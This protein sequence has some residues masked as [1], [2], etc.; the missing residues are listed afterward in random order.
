MAGRA[1]NPDV[2]NPLF[3]LFDANEAGEDLRH[4]I[5]EMS[6]RWN[7]KQL[8][9]LLGNIEA[10]AVDGLGTVAARARLEGEDTAL[11]LMNVRDHVTSHRE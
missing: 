2:D 6:D 1:Q 7:L 10:G 3:A 9:A 4:Q 11:A 8:D 5:V